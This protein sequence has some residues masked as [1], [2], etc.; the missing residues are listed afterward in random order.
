MY[1]DIT[2]LEVAED[3]L[4]PAGSGDLPRLETKWYPH[5]YHQTKVVLFLYLIKEKYMVRQNINKCIEY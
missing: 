2:E 4:H 3:Q 1:M 5:I